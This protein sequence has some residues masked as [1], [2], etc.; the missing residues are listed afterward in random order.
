MRIG[1]QAYLHG[2]IAAVELY[3]KAFGAT[4]GYHERHP[5]G[6]FLHAELYVDGEL[7]LA[8]SEANNTLA[9]DSRMKFS[10]T[11][12]PAMNFCVTLKNERA[13]EKAYDVLQEDANILYPLGSLPWSRCCA[14]L[15]DRFGV[16][17]YI[18]EEGAK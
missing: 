12:Y 9:K 7:L 1:L 15:I 17:W 10:A 16:F 13:V 5:D 6:T 18:S 4:L 3:Q 11:S 8:V 2:S 14:N